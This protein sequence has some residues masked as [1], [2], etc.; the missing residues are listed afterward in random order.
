VTTFTSVCRQQLQ[1]A[2]AI[3]HK[4][5]EDP[6]LSGEVRAKF[7]SIA[8]LIWK[9]HGEGGRIPPGA[10]EALLDKIER[11]NAVNPQPEEKAEGSAKI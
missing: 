1:Q 5:S 11:A 7:Q 2:F 10:G 6:H 9:A 8:R 4:C 3:A